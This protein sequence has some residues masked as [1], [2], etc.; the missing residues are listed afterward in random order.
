M[1]APEALERYPWVFQ[2][3]CSQRD[4]AHCTSTAFHNQWADCR[5]RRRS[6][7]GN[8]KQADGHITWAPLQAGINAHLVV[9]LS[10]SKLE[11]LGHDLRLPFARGA[12]KRP[13][14][15]VWHGPAAALR[16]KNI[17]YWPPQIRN[18]N[19][20]FFLFARIMTLYVF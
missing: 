2:N 13:F 18:Q 8:L 9:C 10:L 5:A 15:E 12:A 6:V 16:F 1:V 11:A 19:L 20:W 17:S 3:L 7:S 4:L 14:I